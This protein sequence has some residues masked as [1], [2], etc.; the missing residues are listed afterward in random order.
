MGRNLEMLSLYFLHERLRGMTMDAQGA[1]TLGGDKRNFTYSR[2]ENLVKVISTKVRFPEP[3]IDA[4][5]K[6]H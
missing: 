3:K 1:L 2:A 4:Q 6:Y 5:S